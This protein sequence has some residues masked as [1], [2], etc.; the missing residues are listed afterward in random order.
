MDGVGANTGPVLADVIGKRERAD[1]LRQILE[2]SRE[3]HEGYASEILLTKNGILHAGRVIEETAFEILMQDDPYA[4]DLL[5]LTP[6]EIDERSTSAIS[7]MPEGLL[8]TFTKDEILD[9]LAYLES[10]V[11]D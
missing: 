7:L 4:E 5:V 2:P 6:D 8:N 1:L 3:I 10:L 9:L 11:E